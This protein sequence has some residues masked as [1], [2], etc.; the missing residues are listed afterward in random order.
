[1]AHHLLKE[2][3]LSEL[4]RIGPERFAQL[5]FQ[6]LEL[7]DSEKEDLL[8]SIC[9][10]HHILLLG[11]PGSGKTRV[12]KNLPLILQDI[13]VVEGCP[14][15]C[16]PEE[17]S[18]PWCED[19]KSRGDKLRSTTLR[20]TDRLIRVQGS[21]G[22]IVEDLIGDLDP[23]A[24]MREGLYSTR[25]FLPGKL[26]RAN[27]CI[28]LIDF[29]DRIPERV[30]NAVMFAL[31]G[32][33]ITLGAL[34]HKIELDTMLVATGAEDALKSLPLDLMDT[35]DVIRLGYV[36][37]LEKQR[38]VVLSHL[39]EDQERLKETTLDQA[40]D[41]V[42]E[43]RTHPEVERGISTRGM[44]KNAELLA[45]LPQMKY[46]GEGAELRVAAMV[47]LPHRLKLAPEVD[48]SGKR[49]QI[50]DGIVRKVTGEQ[51]P[52]EDLAT[53]TKQD[54]LA[55]V[56]EIVREDKFRKP[57]KYGAFDLLLRRI[58]R[59]PESRLAQLY[60]DIACRLPELYPERFGGDSLDDELLEEVEE[61]RKEKETIAKILEQQALAKTLEFLE[62][63]DVLE[64]S[65]SGWM[66]S[67]RGINIL[68]EKLTPRLDESQYIYGYGKHTSGKK[69]SLGEG[70]IVG[71]RHFRFGDKYRDISLKDTMKEAIRNRRTHIT[72]EDMIVNIKEVRARM[73]IVLVVDVS[74]T[75]LQLEKFWYAKQS[76]IALSLAA[77]TQKDRVAVVS[78]SNLADIVVDLTSSPHR[79]TRQVIE[80]ELHEN[81]F[82]NIGY[83]LLK[84]YELLQHHP[85]GRAKQHMI[86]I[87]DG[88][89]T[90]PHPSPPKYALRQAA[91]VSRRGITISCICI[92]QR[93]ADPDL[94]RKIARIGKGRI[95]LIGAEELPTTLVEEA[96]AARLSR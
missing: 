62:K 58:K 70:R 25:A 41:I 10:G 73:D 20:G 12:A 75:M 3:I 59:F 33:T 28:L 71:S 93:S 1:M 89:A 63:Q 79:V 81:A 84:A 53:L 32:G 90:A 87:S 19:R 55:L 91:R 34:D 15:N 43:T 61:C 5:V 86:L 30:L 67:Q 23:E 95:Y 76:A 52:E 31:Q 74:G 82:T 69:L 37:G 40:I 48:L 9:A 80:L 7:Q 47:T 68:L 8:T 50:M 96:I 2:A 60:K 13:E 17:A 78:F 57:L 92:N 85:K 35:F 6:G 65:S 77:T 94:M 83:G 36:E 16:T 27:R 42:N 14:L 54:V 38:K 66:L 4:E 45:Y 44:I 46:E 24:V 56:E 64:R 21:G 39:G 51:A 72:R 29:I 11:P 22:L 26:L 18:C 88:D 49:E